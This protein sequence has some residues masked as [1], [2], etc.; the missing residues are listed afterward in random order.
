M[1]KV[2]WNG[3]IPDEEIK[4]MIDASYAL[5]I[6]SLTRRDHEVVGAYRIV[7]S[8]NCPEGSASSQGGPVGR[9]LMI[10]GSRD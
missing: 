5:I 1:S 10:S 3:V 6:K 9:R 8:G 4:D 7:I 2:H